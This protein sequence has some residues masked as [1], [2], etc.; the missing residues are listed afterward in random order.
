MAGKN[1][2]NY[3]DEIQLSFLPI[4]LVCLGVFLLLSFSRDFVFSEFQPPLWL[5][6]LDL[7]GIA[8][9]LVT[10]LVISMKWLRAAD[11]KAFLFLCY[12]GVAF[13]PSIIVQFDGTPAT[14]ILCSVIFATS[15]LFLSRSHLFASQIVTLA[16]WAFVAGEALLTSTYLVTLV[17]AVAAAA[18]AFW[19]QATRLSHMRQNFQLANR[20]EELETIVPLCASCKKTRDADG[21]W[22][23]IEDYIESQPQSAQVSHALC[24]ACKET[25][26]GDMLRESKEKRAEKLS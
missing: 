11:A 17:L 7:S 18:V 22:M 12:I 9:L 1:W 10:M 16:I 6:V 4:S 19:V 5:I 23:S 15:L 14:L 24:P 3:R 20:V 8:V 26:Y 13:R 25:L 2:Q 21:N